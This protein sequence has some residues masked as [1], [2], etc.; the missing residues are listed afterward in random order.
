MT[1][2]TAEALT[3]H[4]VER[5]A[6]A[7]YDE[8]PFPHLRL[9]EFFPAEHYRALLTNPVDARLFRP[10]KQRD[11]LKPGGG[12]TR[13]KFDLLP[14][15]LRRLSGP[16]HELWATTGA[17]LTSRALSHA[18]FARLRGPLERRFARPID[19]LRLSPEPVL[20]RDSPGYQISNH[21]DSPRKGI[22]LQVYLAEDAGR[23]HLGT[24]FHRSGEKGT[25][26]LDR[27]IPYV[28]NSGYAFPVQSNSFHSVQRTAEEDGLRLS[29]ILTWMV[30][31]RPRDRLR[32]RTKRT[33]NWIGEEVRL[34]FA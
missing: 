26:S 33:L 3:S 4:L 17:A 30:A 34:R 13:M 29:L 24:C 19:R 8:T 16:L 20:L 18:V 6:A 22:T 14:E 15:S 25:G 32:L 11:A 12:S 2:I 10:L 1:A 9:S 5:A 27:V 21:S 7:E 23:P 28:P 31:V